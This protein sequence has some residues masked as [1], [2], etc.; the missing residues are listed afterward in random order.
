MSHE[1][2]TIALDLPCY[3][4]STRSTAGSTTT[5][6]SLG[7]GALT[8]ASSPCRRTSG[9]VA[10]TW[11][12]PFITRSGWLAT[13]IPGAVPSFGW[14]GTHFDT[15]RSLRRHAERAGATPL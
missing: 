9:T 12:L 10:L 11:W 1:P 14:R 7:T 2:E 3:R 5:W 13:K 15:G 6:R 4:K 8:R